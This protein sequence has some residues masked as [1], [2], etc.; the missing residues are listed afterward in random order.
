[1]S[2]LAV[3][4]LYLAFGLSL[5][6]SPATWPE[7]VR[8]ATASS[9]ARRAFGFCK[10]YTRDGGGFREAPARTCRQSRRAAVEA[11]SVDAWQVLDPSTAAQP[12]VVS[13]QQ[14]P[15]V[16]IISTPAPTAQ[17]PE[18]GSSLI[19]YNL[20]CSALALSAEIIKQ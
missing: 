19:S 18:H 1:M 10:L 14:R 11:G 2:I 3:V 4:R 17:Q 13:V 15:G 20:P 9:P 5:F 8:S 6:W 7:K 12:A 16:R